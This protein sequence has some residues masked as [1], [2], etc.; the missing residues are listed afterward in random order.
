MRVL[1][2]HER[3]LPAPASTVGSLIDGLAGDNDRL[4]PH[5]RWPPMRFDRPLSTRAAGGHGPV[6]YRVD[7]YT[8]GQRIVFR[9][10]P[11]RG[12]TRGFQGVHFFEIKDNGQTSVLK[13]VIDA[14]CSFPAWLRWM[15]IVRPLHDALL[16]DALDKAVRTVDGRVEHPAKWSGWVRFLRRLAAR[17]RLT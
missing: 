17:R 6:R 8:H 9:F 14:K 4:W 10:D 7:A 13:H 16:E 1:N 12:L 5:D 3:E 11:E 2:V 15:L